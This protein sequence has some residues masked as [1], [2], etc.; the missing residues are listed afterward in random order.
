MSFGGRV[1]EA[2]RRAGSPL[3]L[4]I[5]PREADIAPAAREA[6]RARLGPDAPPIAVRAEAVRRFSLALVEVAAA[7]RLA[8]VK[9]QSAFY[10]A[11][12]PAGAAALAEAL[13]AARSAGLIAIADVKRGDIGSTAEAYAEAYLGPGAPFRADAA[14]VSPYLGRDSLE[15]WLAAARRDGAAGIFVLVRTSN[16]GARDIQERRLA[17]AATEI[18][19][20]S[21]VESPGGGAR[22]ASR[23]TPARTPGGQGDVSRATSLPRPPADVSDAVAE[24]VSQLSQDTSDA[25]GYGAVGAVVG[26]TAPG[27]AARLRAALPAAILLAPGVGAQGAS[28]A[29]LAP[30]FDARGLGALVPVSRAISGAWREAAPGVAWEDACR[31]AVRRLRDEIAKAVGPRGR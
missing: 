21:S 5:D 25:S 19:G 26:A 22:D 31:A 6:A 17:D 23:A 13:A 14:T 12:G 24:V 7:E 8:A 16:P 2:V 1:V 30:F 11:A 18:H 28:A 29:D 10:E 15:P 27:A 3:V 20:A 4:G 9:L